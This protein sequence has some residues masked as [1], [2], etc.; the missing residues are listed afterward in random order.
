[1]NEQFKKKF[2]TALWLMFATFVAQF[3]TY[4]IDNIAEFRL[5]PLVAVISVGVCT[6]LVATITKMLNK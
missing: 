5:T 6:A 3:L 1:M 4:L 2:A